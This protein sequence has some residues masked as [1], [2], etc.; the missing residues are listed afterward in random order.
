VVLFFVHMPFTVTVVYKY[1]YGNFAILI[2][3]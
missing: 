2:Q 1:G 3:S